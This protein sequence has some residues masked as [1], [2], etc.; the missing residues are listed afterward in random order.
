MRRLLCIMLAAGLLLIPLAYNVQA[1]PDTKSAPPVGQPLVREGDFAGALVETLGL[2]TANDEAQAEDTLAAAGIQ[3]KNGWVANYP[4]TPDILGELQNTV[5]SAADT[6]QLKITRAEAIKDFQAVSEDYGLPI[7]EENQTTVLGE[8]TQYSYSESSTSQES[9]QYPD[10]TVVENYYYEEGPPVVT[11]Y[12]P[13]WDYAYLYGWVPYPFWWSGFF[14]PGFFA[15][16]DFNFFFDFDHFHHFHD[17][18]HD[19][20]RF[21]HDHNRFG[22]DHNGFF[23]HRALVSNHVMNRSTGRVGT[24]DPARRALG[25]NAMFASNRATQRGF[26]SQ[27]AKTGAASI[28]A[29]SQ[30]R[31]LAGNR[32][33]ASNRSLGVNRGSSGLAGHNGGRTANLASSNRMGTR[34]NGTTGRSFSRGSTNGFHSGSVNASRGFDHRVPMNGG[35]RSFAGNR[36][37]LTAPRLGG[38]NSFRSWNGG[39]GG[40]SFAHSGGSPWMGGGGFSRG[41]GSHGGSFA[42]GGGGFHGGGGGFHGG[43]GGH[44]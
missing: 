27:A 34:F 6:G 25:R 35:A 26:T 29:R 18:D 40:R 37:S 16:N 22:H 42:M 10:S 8:Q 13:P 39:M 17:F 14:F 38:S 21:D 43:G 36:D 4:V 23:H 2:G 11:Y 9:A 15:L 5:T 44:R 19:H 3:P 41:G 24:I 31:A 1:A 7:A 32:N 28:M 30:Q 12:Q 33:L 20:H